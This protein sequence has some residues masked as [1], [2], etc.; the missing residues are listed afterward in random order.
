MLL[1]P[2]LT[3]L[4]VGAAGSLYGMGRMV[5]VSFPALYLC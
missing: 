1:Y 3:L 4:A 5:A 2:Y